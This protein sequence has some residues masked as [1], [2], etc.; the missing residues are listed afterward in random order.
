MLNLFWVSVQLKIDKCDIRK[1]FKGEPE[2]YSFL[3]FYSFLLIFHNSRMMND[4]KSSLM[5]KQSLQ[6]DDD[7]DELV[8]LF[9]INRGSV[10]LVG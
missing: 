4:Q 3:S 8:H 6:N 7:D 5:L 10:K 1:I 9:S 2:I